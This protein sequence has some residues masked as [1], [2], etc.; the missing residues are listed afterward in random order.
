MSF[1]PDGR[2]V[3]FESFIGSTADGGVYV[4]DRDAGAPR[5]LADG[6]DPGWSPDGRLIAFKV[7]DASDRYWLHVM[8]ADGSNDRVLEE[9]TIPRW[10]PDGRRLAYMAPVD[11]GWQI[12][13]V[14][15][16]SGEVTR[17][18]P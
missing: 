3:L 7:H 17:L 9:G 18:T 8:D 14:D 13:V 15:V 1:S 5:R 4:V 12:H 2:S 16:V 11:G 6:T 10:F